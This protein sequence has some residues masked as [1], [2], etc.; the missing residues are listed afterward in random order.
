MGWLNAINPLASIP[1]EATAIQA[2]R[3]AAIAL[4][5]G[6]IYALVIVGL[7]VSSLQAV[8]NATAAE[9]GATG[10]E[11][12]LGISMIA[13]GI[14]FG[15]IQL[16]AG[17]FQWKR[18]GLVLPII[19][20]ILVV[21]GLVQSILTMSGMAPGGHGVMSWIKLALLAVQAVLCFSAIRAANV[22]ERVRRAQGI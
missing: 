12:V 18:P 13:A 2:S 14:L 5:L 8:A 19:V 21:W 9:F 3:G 17:A 1:D 4:F 10:H 15:A 22:L 7:N 20:M 11:S 6:G 16:A